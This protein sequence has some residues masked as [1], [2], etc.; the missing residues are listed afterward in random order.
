MV[1]QDMVSLDQW[2]GLAIIASYLATMPENAHHRDP[3]L[4]SMGCPWWILSD[5]PWGVEAEGDLL[6]TAILEELLSLQEEGEVEGEEVDHDS[7][8][9]H[10][11][12][13]SL[14]EKQ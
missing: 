8:C 12:E 1:L 13:N 7:E 11:F 9:V 4:V 2:L 10:N 3:F 5:H 14:P 6:E